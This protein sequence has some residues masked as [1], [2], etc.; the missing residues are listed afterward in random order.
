MS[1]LFCIGAMCAAFAL[2][3]GPP[4]AAAGEVHQGQLVEK[5]AVSSPGQSVTL[6]SEETAAL[7]RAQVVVEQKSEASL[8][9]VAAKH[10]SP[11]LEVGGVA[12]GTSIVA[13]V[14]VI[15]ANQDAAGSVVEVAQR[16]LL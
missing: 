7:S 12:F 14:A 9:I 5:A 16:L 4:G 13:Q 3:V 11:Q 15:E 8:G 2:S 10:A 1:R 6:V